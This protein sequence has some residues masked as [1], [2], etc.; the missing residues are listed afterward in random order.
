MK[1]G[2]EKDGRKNG[3]T[4]DEEERKGRKQRETEEGE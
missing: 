4:N 1:K 3:R 2:W